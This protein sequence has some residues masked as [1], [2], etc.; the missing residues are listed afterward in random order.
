[1]G[2]FVPKKGISVL[3][4]ALQSLR[5]Q[6]REPEAVIV[7]DGP[8]AQ[9][10]HRQA[11]GLTRLRFL[12]WQT[13]EAVAALMQTAALMVVPSIRAE[14][15]D[16]EGLPSVAL[17]AMAAGLPVVASDEAGLEGVVIPDETGA[18]VAAG[19]PAAL[20]AAIARLM[21]DPA[22]RSRLGAAAAR[23]TRR[24]YDAAE[25]SR[26]LEALLLRAMA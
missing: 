18:M 16:A 21:A 23:L 2:R 22:G 14:D 10:I 6:G 12:G 7:G 17:E 19:D 13:P 3:I 11:A 24:S 25:Q 1:V 4:D 15:G 8:L 20:A 26:K 9:A 5:A